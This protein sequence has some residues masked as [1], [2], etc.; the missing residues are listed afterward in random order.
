MPQVRERNPTLVGCLRLAIQIEKTSFAAMCEKSNSDYLPN[1]A[2]EVWYSE[3]LNC[4]GSPEQLSSN[5]YSK[6]LL[7]YARPVL[8]HLL[9][10]KCPRHHTDYL[11]RKCWVCKVHA[12]AILCPILGHFIFSESKKTL[13]RI[14]TFVPGTGIKYCLKPF[15]PIDSYSNILLAKYYYY[16]ANFHFQKD[17]R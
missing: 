9:H 2:L 12:P 14:I 8:F 5:V 4:K 10:L 11:Q 7:I 17:Y 6:V 13:P 3:E 15:K 16:Y 1:H